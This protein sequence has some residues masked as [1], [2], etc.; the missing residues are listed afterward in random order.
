MWNT[1]RTDALGGIVASVSM[2]PG[3][4][5]DQ[6]HAYV[7]RPDGAGP[8]PGIVM[9]HHLPG[10]D[11]FYR[12]FAR[13][14]AEHGYIAVVPNLFE[15]FGHGTPDDVAAAARAAGG[16]SDESVKGDAGQSMQWI[17]AQPFSNGKVGVIGTCSGGRHA[18]L[19]ASS[20]PGF[21]A[22]ADLWGAN[23]VV[24]PDRLTPQQPVAVIDL[25]PNLNVP[26]LGLF[27]ND[28]MGPSPAQVDQH[29][30]ALQAAGKDYMFH[31]YDGAGHGFFYYHMPSYRQQQAM[32]GW[33]K[34]DDFFR[35]TLA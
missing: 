30:A 19:V 26:L 2:L 27:G 11:E 18:L 6:V 3:G 4:Q 1:F 17:K 23:V 32:D 12:E 13:R 8:Y 35:Q 15:R 22:V 29:E 14:F 25:T 7:A 5:D 31:R 21:D 28:D 24:T 33:N 20:V 34:V 9:T 10:W 16:V